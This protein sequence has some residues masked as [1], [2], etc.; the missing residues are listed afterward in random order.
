MTRAQL[1]LKKNEGPYRETICRDIILCT[2]D[3]KVDL[4]S[5]WKFKDKMLEVCSYMNVHKIVLRSDSFRCFASRDKI[6]TNPPTTINRLITVAHEAAHVGLR[7]TRSMTRHRMEFETGMLERQFILYQG[8]EFPMKQD[9]LARRYVARIIGMAIRRGVR[10]FDREAWLYARSIRH[11]EWMEKT[12]DSIEPEFND[13][14]RDNGF[15]EAMKRF[16]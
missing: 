14:S 10:R 6:F 13:Q 9:E 5:S 2:N 12:L 11:P 3:T 15:K 1:S 8:L 16:S 4:N 7:H